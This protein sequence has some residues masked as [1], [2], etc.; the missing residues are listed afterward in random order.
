MSS[1]L[2]P[3]IFYSSCCIL[4]SVIS[5]RLK[6]TAAAPHSWLSHRHTHFLTQSHAETVYEAPS[7]LKMFSQT[8]QVTAV[9]KVPRN[10]VELCFSKSPLLFTYS[11]PLP[12]PLTLPVI[13]SYT[14]SGLTLHS[15]IV[16]VEEGGR[17]YCSRGQCPVT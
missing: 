16:A 8:S 4:L 10:E 14:H 17:A 13:L 9:R 15:L 2:C 3:C 6:V 5:N 11:F 12:Q 1:H 7:E